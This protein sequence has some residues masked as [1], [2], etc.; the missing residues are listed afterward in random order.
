M[1]YP[2]SAINW[3]GFALATC[4]GFPNSHRREDYRREDTQFE[5]YADD[6]DEEVDGWGEHYE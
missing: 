6:W 2:L 1:N 3:A 4:Y 5:H